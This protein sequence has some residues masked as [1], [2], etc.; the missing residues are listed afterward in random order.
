MQGSLVSRVVVNF[1]HG[2]WYAQGQE[3]LRKIIAGLGLPFIGLAEYPEGCPSHA[4]VQYAFK[5]ATVAF[6]RQCGYREII[7]MDCSAV[8]TGPLDPIFEVMEEHGA[9]VSANYGWLSKQWTTDECFQTMGMS[10]SQHGEVPHCATGVVGFNLDHPK[11][12]A[13]CDSWYHY[14]LKTLAFRGPHKI[15]SVGKNP[16]GHRHDQ[17]VMSLL[18]WAHDV[19]LQPN[20]RFMDYGPDCK[21]L[22]RMYPP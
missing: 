7:W 9:F 5:P 19:P 13:I 10:R 15:D 18:A 8:P 14:G 20:D 22:V 11:G 12:L 17:S 21:A 4:E 1:A 2:G 16:E 6:A 3:R